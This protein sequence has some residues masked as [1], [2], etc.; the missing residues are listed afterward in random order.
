MSSPEKLLNGQTVIE[1]VAE[2]EPELIHIAV[3]FAGRL[4]SD[5]GAHVIRVV[6]ERDLLVRL[7]SSADE[8]VGDSSVLATYLNRNKVLL[9][10]EEIGSVEGEAIQLVLT[11]SEGEA[12]PAASRV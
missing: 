5:L 2:S 4:L 9:N 7:R 3:S 6:P 10:L 1:A 8:Q 12:F 11:G